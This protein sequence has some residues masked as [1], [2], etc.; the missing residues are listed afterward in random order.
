MPNLSLQELHDCEKEFEDEIQQNKIL[1]SQNS[2]S[3]KSL[4]ETRTLSLANRRRAQECE[5]KLEDEIEAK[6][7]L[8]KKYESLCPSWCEWSSCSKICRGV[9][10]RMNKCSIHDEETE[11]C[12]ENFPQSGESVG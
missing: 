1:Q 4:E 3:L 10:T 5:N 8:Q 9:K 11:P 7:S 6:D 2:K 12:N